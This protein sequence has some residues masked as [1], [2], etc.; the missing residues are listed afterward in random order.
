MDQ[1]PQS[2]KA[3]EVSFCIPRKVRTIGLS[4]KLCDWRGSP[5]SDKEA[6]LHLHAQLSEVHPAAKEDTFCLEK[7]MAKL[8]KCFGLC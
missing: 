8:E 2:L 4:S 7:K 6:L 5:E 1:L 3:S